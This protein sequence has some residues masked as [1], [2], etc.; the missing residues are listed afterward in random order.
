M[1]ITEQLKKLA[2]KAQKLGGFAVPFGMTMLELFAATAPEEPQWWIDN[3][4]KSRSEEKKGKAGD[5]L[6]RLVQWRWTYA[7][8]MVMK[9]QELEKASS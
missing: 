8:A 4:N 3:W 6:M 1:T 2:D 5:E 7:Q 9:K